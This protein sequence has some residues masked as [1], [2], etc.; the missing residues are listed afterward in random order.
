MATAVYHMPIG[1]FAA[2]SATNV[3][4]CVPAITCVL[5]AS[6]GWDMLLPAEP[7]F[8]PAR[9]STQSFPSI[10]VTAPPTYAV[11]D[12]IDWFWPYKPSGVPQAIINGIVRCGPPVY[13]LWHGDHMITLPMPRLIKFGYMLQGNVHS[14]FLT[15]AGGITDVPNNLPNASYADYALKVEPMNT[16]AWTTTFTALERGGFTPAMLRFSIDGMPLLVSQMAMNLDLGA[17][18][19]YAGGVNP[20]T[21]NPMPVDSVKNAEEEPVWYWAGRPS[22][23]ISLTTPEV[24]KAEQ[25]VAKHHI[26]PDVQIDIPTNAIGAANRWLRI[27]IPRMV[28]TVG[29]NRYLGHSVTLY[30]LYLRMIAYP[31]VFSIVSS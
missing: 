10:A 15:F 23:E 11:E 7:S 27:T 31:P 22:L 8:L 3:W 20:V 25:L 26:V 18:P 13:F 24:G 21:V 19:S 30:S 1:R 16:P 17:T 14:V 12:I 29:L 28:S 4:L 6:R 9:V 5:T 2:R